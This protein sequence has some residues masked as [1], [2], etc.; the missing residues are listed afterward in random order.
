VATTCTCTCIVIVF[1]EERATAQSTAT[2]KGAD[3]S[4]IQEASHGVI[5]EGVAFNRL[6]GR[7]GGV[8]LRTIPAVQP[9][10]IPDAAPDNGATLWLNLRRTGVE[11]MGGGTAGQRRQAPA[12]VLPVLRRH[13]RWKQ[14]RAT[15][16]PPSPSP[17]LPLPLPL[18]LALP[19]PPPLLGVACAVVPQVLGRS[20]LVADLV[21]L[22]S[23]A[24]NLAATDSARSCS[25]MPPRYPIRAGAPG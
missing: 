5:Y 9:G 14:A 15:G 1:Q 22:D 2:D 8:V 7:G 19:L 6:S 20:R 23:C 24:L 21:R 16:V 10:R 11:S 3:A 13:P 17:S 25:L 18:P 12:P 4:P